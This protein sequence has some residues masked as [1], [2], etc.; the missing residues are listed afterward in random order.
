MIKGVTVNLITLEETGRDALNA[1]IYSEVSTPIDNVLIAPASSQEVLE[2]LE[3]H[4]K[5]VV[6]TLGIPKTDTHDWTNQK[7]EFWGERYEVIGYPTRGI[8]D[9]IPLDWNMKVQVARYE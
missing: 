5:K 9:L 3:L 4:N 6:Y 7:V 1:P 8:D 2:S